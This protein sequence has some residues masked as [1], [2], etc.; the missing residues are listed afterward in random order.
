MAIQLI[1]CS[2]VL[3]LQ[4]NSKKK[5][6]SLYNDIQ[7]YLVTSSNVAARK[8]NIC[9]LDQNLETHKNIYIC[10]FL[11]SSCCHKLV[12]V[13]FCPPEHF[14]LHQKNMT[15]LFSSWL[16]S[17]TLYLFMW[18]PSIHFTTSAPFSVRPLHDRYKIEGIEN[19]KVDKV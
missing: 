5:N 19:L 3:V 10:I 1:C 12:F 18:M 16:T 2:P 9:D 11:T 17:I 4:Y 15:F 14:L 6:L 8:Q 13:I 7:K